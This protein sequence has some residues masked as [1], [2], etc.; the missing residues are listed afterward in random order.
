M[1]TT[2]KTWK[3]SPGP[4]TFNN[5][6]GGE[7]YDARKE[8]TGWSH[9][10]FDDKEW[11]YV[12]LAGESSGKLK[13]LMM[14]PLTVTNTIQPVKQLNPSP[15]VYLFDLGQN[16]AG[17]WHIELK[18][19]SGQVIRV[20]ADET[21]NDTLP[22][23]NVVVFPKPMEEGDKL[24]TNTR[25]HPYTWTDY[26]IKGNGKE[27]YEPRFFYTG[28]RYMEVITS[29]RK[30]LEYL[31]ITGRVVRT[32]VE[33]NGRFESSDSMLN[34]I[35]RTGLW[36]QMGN[37][38][39]YPTD[40]PQREKGAY[41]GDGQVMA[42]TS[43]HDFDMAALYTKWV[44][45]M[46]DA[47]EE[48]G[49][50]P[51]TTPTLVGGM[52]GG[53]AWGSAYILIP[54]W[55]YNYYGDTR[56][57][58]EHY[59]AMKRYLEYLKQLALTDSNPEESYIINDF[60]TYWHSLGEWLSPGRKNCPNPPVIHT[61]YYYYNHLLFSKIAAV[62]GYSEDSMYY[63]SLSDTIKQKFN[64]KFF[65]PMTSL[66]GTLETY[67]TYQLLAL[68]GDMVSDDNKEKVFST[69]VND[70]EMRG[71]KLNTGILGTKYLWPMLVKYGREELAFQLATQNNYPGYGYWIENNMTTFPEQW[72]G[73]GSKNHQM[74]GS[75]VEYFYKQLAGIQA[76]TDGLTSVGYQD[77][78][79]QPYV[80][81]G[82]DYLNTTY[83]T[84][85]G[86]I[87][88]SW[89]KEDNS[90]LFTVTI[91]ANTYAT[92]SLPLFNYNEAIVW[93]G[94]QIIWENNC[95]HKEPYGITKVYNT[96]NRIIV[97]VLSGKYEFSVKKKE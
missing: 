11:N 31:K 39:S 76:P 23:N 72:D 47:Q 56:V 69:I 48:N 79:I 85:A 62:L 58:E 13:S 21:L 22:G 7:D 43:I 96:Q 92:V 63:K 9:S 45:D 57:L 97:H 16:I 36:S 84:V 17:W 27:I 61:F 53:I 1:V 67:Q 68:A 29:D 87:G 77:I 64:R 25:Y 51:N 49:R 46:R 37:F 10:D 5:L 52:G 44:S 3:Y 54:W 8:I 19:T 59:Q 91:P 70:I 93:E 26:T 40:C 14:P 15:G 74:F 6:Y 50:I 12:S 88:S 60:G 75:V 86:E 95:V 82:L 83:E 20:R 33:R 24:S 80:P 34:R 41:L 89:K 35:H 4:V 66:Y 78:Y 55:L 18:G 38:H 42:E 90:F 2:D 73:S 94:D 30:N 28:F 65:N 81:D 32:K 71:G